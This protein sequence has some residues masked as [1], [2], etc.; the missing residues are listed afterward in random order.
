M[1]VKMEILK[2]G[3]LEYKVRCLILEMLR[4]PLYEN[5]NLKLYCFNF[6]DVLIG[7]YY[8]FNFY[9]IS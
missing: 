8:L 9:T 6:Y 4:I 1:V 3:L 5:T 7:I 2:E